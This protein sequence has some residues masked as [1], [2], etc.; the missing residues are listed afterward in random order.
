MQPKTLNLLQTPS[1]V[2]GLG[3][4]TGLP[5]FLLEACRGLEVLG[6]G[7]MT[8]CA[9]NLA[10]RPYTSCNTVNLRLTQSHTEVLN[11]FPEKA[12]PSKA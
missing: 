4:I 6:L 11:L 7:V 8:G 10:E 2:L 9:E 5:D 3:I 12:E 1:G